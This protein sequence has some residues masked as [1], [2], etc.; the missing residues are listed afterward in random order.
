[1]PFPLLCLLD[2]KTTEYEQDAF[3]ARRAESQKD[4]GQYLQYGNKGHTCLSW[5]VF[6]AELQITFILASVLTV[7]G[8]VH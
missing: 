6:T 5:K 8:K 7:R 2:I 4:M 3:I 1:M